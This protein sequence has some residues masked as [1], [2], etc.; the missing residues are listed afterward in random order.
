M[1]ACWPAARRTPAASNIVTPAKLKAR[2]A[3]TEP[4]PSVRPMEAASPQVMAE[5][6]LGMPPVLTR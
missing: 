1:R 5:C 2:M 6:A 4:K 3:A